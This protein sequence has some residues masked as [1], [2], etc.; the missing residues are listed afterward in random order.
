MSRDLSDTELDGGTKSA[1]APGTQLLR[2]GQSFRGVT[3]RN[4]LGKG[5]M[6]VAYLASH[7]SLKMP[8]VIKL[9]TI[10][11]EEPLAE[12]H[13]AARVLSSCVVPVL[14]AGIE[15]GMPYVMQRYVDGI[16]LDELLRI[17][18]ALDR[19]I[20]IP[21]LIRLG[22]DVLRGLSAIHVAGVI[23][24]DIKPPNLFLGGSGE[25]L[26]GDF[27]IAV[28]PQRASTAVGVAGTPMFIA[29]EVWAGHPATPQS[30]LYSAAATL[31]LLWQRRA[32]FHSYDMQELHAMHRDQPY[33]PPETADPV[34]A[35]LGAVLARM[36]SKAPEARPESA[37]A[38]ARMLGRLATPA[39]ELHGHDDGIASV[40][41]IM[42]ALEVRDITGAHTDVIV[43]AANEELVMDMGVA[44]ALRQAGGDELEAAAMAQAPVPMG[45]VVWTGPG[46]LGCKAVAHA[47]AAMDGAICIQRAVLRT[48]FEAERR[49]YRTVTF[50]ALGTGIG[51]VPHGLGARLML[52]AIRTFASFDP[53]ICRSIR[54]ALPTPTATSTWNQALLALDADA[55]AT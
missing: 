23:H 49:G 36:L 35:Y 47:V 14:D 8:V 43:S 25:A 55:T 37:L 5:A 13:L 38:A 51:G 30:D 9:F 41:N 46:R 32:P 6:G 11:M 54:I 40:G 19:S 42:V 33:K 39:P 21:V 3:I 15:Q 52:E 27:G 48:L 29:P 10:T 31:H 45:Q 22:V 50:P 26:V 2:R 1:P 20:P 17:H 4:V 44:G 28:D 7:A 53:K 12:A 18:I 16:D 34:G 24:R